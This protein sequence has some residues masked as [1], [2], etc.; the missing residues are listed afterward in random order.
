MVVGEIEGFEQILRH[1]SGNATFSREILSSLRLE[2]Q[3]YRSTATD[4]RVR[5]L[6]SSVGQISNV[7]HSSE[8]QL[9]VLVHVLL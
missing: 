9:M 1:L 6:D 8:V 7:T 5:D 2:P 4:S 3:R